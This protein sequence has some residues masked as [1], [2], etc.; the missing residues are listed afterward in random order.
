MGVTPSGAERLWWKKGRSRPASDDRKGDKAGSLPTYYTG[1][2]AHRWCYFPRHG[3]SLDTAGLP[4]P[5]N[6]PPIQRALEVL[7]VLTQSEIERE[8]YEA[9]LKGLRD[10]SAS[11]I[12]AKEE[13]RKEGHKEGALMGRIQACQNFLKQPQTPIEELETRS[14]EELELQFKQLETQVLQR[15]SSG[16]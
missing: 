8:R 16:A 3:E 10:Q 15:L 1:D 14:R 7:S 2:V 11:L 6:I 13:G 5:L 12:G 9:R 4:G